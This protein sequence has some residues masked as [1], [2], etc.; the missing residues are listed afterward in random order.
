MINVSVIN[1]LK[2]FWWHWV[3]LDGWVPCVTTKALFELQISKVQCAGSYLLTW[4]C[5]SFQLGCALALAHA[6]MPASSLLEALS[7]WMQS[8]SLTTTYNTCQS[9]W[10]THV[11]AR[12][13]TILRRVSYRFEALSKA[14]QAVQANQVIGSWTMFA[15]DSHS[16]TSSSGWSW[17]S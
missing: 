13:W 15:I 7:Q 16:R 17:I 10:V 6:V 3:R 8:Q 4:A 12:Q 2:S 11:R 9:L 1:V 5:S 14:L